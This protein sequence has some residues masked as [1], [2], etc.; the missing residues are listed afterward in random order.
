MNILCDTCSVLMLIRIAPEMF[1]DDRFECVTIREVIKELFQTQRF[2]TSYPWRKEYKSKIKAMGTSE[3][4]KGDFQVCYDIIKNS[5]QTGK[6]NKRTGR[7][8]N[9]SR[10]DQTIAACSIA[11]NFKLTTVDKD[12][13]DFIK[14][15]FSG[16]TITPLGIINNWLEKGLIKW[17]EKMQMV[18]EDWDACNESPQP[19][20]EL[21]RFEKNTGYKYAGPK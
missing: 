21:K 4:K 5:I 2:K 9:L 18:I 8:F 19:R 11:H 16:Q 6:I 10:I 15:E 20:R 14:Q 12:L 1:F 13:K 3:M 7:Y 17:D